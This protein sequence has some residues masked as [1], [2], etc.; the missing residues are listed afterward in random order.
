MRYISAI[1]GL[2]LLLVAGCASVP[3]T[4]DLPLADPQPSLGQA[5]NNPDQ[6]RGSVVR[7]G[8]TIIGVDNTRDGTVVEV[9]ARPLDSSSRPDES[10]IS[11]GRF[12]VETPHF[13][14]P[15]VYQPGRS[16]TAVGPL[17]GIRVRQV[18]EYDYRYP[19]LRAERYHLWPP[20][21]ERQARTYDP[22]WDPYWRHPHYRR[23]HP[24]YHPYYFW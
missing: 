23:Y 21:V 4:L 20:R 6:V 10:A 19:V 2:S 8:G 24:Y 1:V 12:L 14:D 16:F 18:G 17:D 13:L 9:V 22:F 11:P 7:W 5:Q 15:E 3:A